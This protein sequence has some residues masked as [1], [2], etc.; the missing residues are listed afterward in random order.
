MSEMDL[1][2]TPGRTYKYSHDPNA[3]QF[4]FASGLQFARFS[5]TL[6]EQPAPRVVLHTDE[7]GGGSD[8]DGVA[9][10]Y[11]LMLRNLLTS[12]YPAEV[13]VTMFM[14]PTALPTQP[15]D[16]PLLTHR[17]LVSFQVRAGPFVCNHMVY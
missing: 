9:T 12:K 1:A 10:V 5:L 17:Q 4:E 7:V 11:S 8:G 14:S 13:V 15:K 16:H 6:Q 3:M 2:A